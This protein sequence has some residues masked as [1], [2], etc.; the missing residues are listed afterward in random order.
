MTNPTAGLTDGTA[1]L[2]AIELDHAMRSTLT[3]GVDRLTRELGRF[4]RATDL[5]V[6]HLQRARRLRAGAHI[7]DDPVTWQCPPCGGWVH[8][9][10]AE[11]L[12]PGVGCRCTCQGGPIR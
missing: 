3:A 11:V 7:D 2:R 6:D 1:I 12:D 9:A 4:A 8:D 10:C 5:A